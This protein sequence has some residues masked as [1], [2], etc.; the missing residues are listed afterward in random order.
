MKRKI[1]ICA[2]V[3]LSM[4]LSSCSI[5]IGGR[6]A[7]MNRAEEASDKTIS[8]ANLK[9]LEVSSPV[10]SIN[11]KTWD[12]NEV[13]V[14]ITKVNNGLKSKSELLDE[15][16]NAEIVFKEENEKLSV[17]A[18]LPKFKNNGISIQFE[19]SVPKNIQVC[20]IDAE[21]GD[22]RVRDIQGQI[23]VTNNVGK[24]D[25]DNCIGL[26]NLKAVTGDVTVRN[27]TLKPDSNLTSN[28]GR[29]L[30]DGVIENKGAYKITTNVGKVD[31]TLPGNSAFDIDA[32]TNVGDIDCGF[33]VSGSRE[34]RSIKGKVNGGGAQLRLINNTGSISINKK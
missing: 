19:I 17:K 25:I 28:V 10:G 5:N 27:S 8:M 24:I 26:I 33:D 21:V 4:L 23:D 11:V 6:S 32:S 31:V 13:Y 9:T 1:V 18:F 34:K 3:V 7:G 20:K 30:F 12:K 29:V 2:L 14:K 16:K 22:V 15:L